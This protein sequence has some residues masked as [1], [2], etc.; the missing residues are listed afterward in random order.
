[1]QK[2]ERE[3]LRRLFKVKQ[4]EGEMMKER[5]YRLDRV[6]QMTIQNNNISFYTLI[7]PEFYNLDYTFD[8][9]LEFRST[10]NL[11]RSRLEF[12]CL[13]ESPNDPQDRVIVLYIT[14]QPSKKS[15]KEDINILFYFIKDQNPDNKVKHFILISE[16]GIQPTQMTTINNQ[17]SGYNIEIF[18]DENLA[19]NYSKHAYCPIDVKLVKNKDVKKWEEEE[20]LVS[21]QLPLIL[22]T[23]PL[24]LWY[25]AKSL[26]V[27]QTRILG[28]ETDEAIYYRIV[29]KNNALKK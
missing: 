13:Y 12:S 23:D 16:T 6:H 1:M 24:S 9:F 11:F 15:S 8:K 25:N 28:M 26:D 18:R 29:R 17:I 2:E 22:D 27:F 14:N 4:T 5:G 10:S 20:G 3:I 19:F 7:N 21:S